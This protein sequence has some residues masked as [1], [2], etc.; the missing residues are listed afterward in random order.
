MYTM[1]IIHIVVL[2]ILSLFYQDSDRSPQVSPAITHQVKTIIVKKTLITRFVIDK[3]YK[4]TQLIE[5]SEQVVSQSYFFNV[6]TENKIK[7]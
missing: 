2:F 3:I 5:T 7:T 4:G 1:Y 6:K